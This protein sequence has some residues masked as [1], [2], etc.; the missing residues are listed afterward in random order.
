DYLDGRITRAQAVELTRKY[1][2]VSPVRAEKSVAFIDQ[3]RSY[4]IN[5]GLGQDMAR[6]YVEGAGADPAERW[7]AMTKILSEP[8]LP[9][10]LR[11]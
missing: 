8:T 9:R 5:Y 3:Y 1:Q 11:R 4:V 10:D 6:A 7:A 2:L